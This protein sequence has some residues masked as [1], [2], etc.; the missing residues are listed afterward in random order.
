MS[1][2]SSAVLRTLGDAIAGDVVL[3]VDEGWQAARQAWNLT[4][5]PRPAAVVYPESPADMRRIVTVAAE[6]DLRVAFVAGGHNAGPID[7]SRDAL[8]VKTERMREIEIDPAERR[9]RVGAGVLAK[10]LAEAAGEHGLAFLAGTSPDAGVAGYVLGGGFS[11]MIR[12]HGLACNSILGVELVTADG[13]LVRADASNEPDLFWALR[14]G[15]G[16]FGAVTA[17]ELAL[18]PV[19]ELYAGCLFWPIERAA[20]ILKAWFEWTGSAPLEC[21][22]IGRMLQLPDAPFLPPHLNARSFVLVEAAH[23]GSQAEG[24]ALLAPLR[25]LEPEFDTFEMLPA[26]SLSLV[27]MDPDFPLPYAGDGALL[28]SLTPDLIDRLV[29]SFV[30]SPVLHAEIRHLGGAAAEGSPEHGAL[31][32]VEQPFV[33]FTFGL[34]FDAEQHA[35]VEHHVE[36][37]FA[38]VEPWNSGK[39]YLNFTEVRAD[40]RTM[41]P[42]DCYDRLLAIKAAYDPDGRFLAN[43]S[44]PAAG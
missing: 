44:I 19:A 28:S 4:A 23:L 25:A 18:Y 7:W 21:H 34:A 42:D 38:A 13:R 17:I 30:G 27:N 35:A 5:D 29:D 15:G 14:G 43:H 20:E 31:D 37:I 41:F 3:P 6:H 32:R 33:L 22:S 8:L 39:R 10:P 9:A 24:E 11:W 36:G 40:C 2:T 12:K 1:T 26:A 16:N